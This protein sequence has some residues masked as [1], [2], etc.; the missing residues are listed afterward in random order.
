MVERAAQQANGAPS[1]DVP[2]A[3]LALRDLAA[4]DQVLAV[5]RA[6]DVAAVPG[7]GPALHYLCQELV[8]M[9]PPQPR[10]AALQ[11]LLSHRE[12]AVRQF[13]L[14]MLAELRDVTALPWVTARVAAEQGDLQALA[15]KVAAV[16]AT[17]PPSSD[18]LVQGRRNLRTLTWR[19]A[20]WWR[21]SDDTQKAMVVGIPCALATLLVVAI[22]LG[23]RRPDR[24]RHGRRR[25][26][27][28]DGLR[29]RGRRRGRGRPGHGRC[30]PGRRG[31]RRCCRPDGPRRRRLRRRTR[32]RR[33][34]RRDADAAR[35]RGRGLRTV[36]R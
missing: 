10:L 13:A 23:R 11:A 33:R 25:L 7:S 30:R 5:A 14:T 32:R 24:V 27:R 29:R 28:P 16:L 4:A 6:L 2:A 8:P 22:V 12:A 35:A 19:A 26:R 18:P 9:L 20:S 15:T 17:P 3:L 1:P 34:A 21:H 31:R 36:N